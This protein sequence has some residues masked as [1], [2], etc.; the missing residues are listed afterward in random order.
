MIWIT[1]NILRLFL[2]LDW[3][4]DRHRDSV[5]ILWEGLAWVIIFNR[6]FDGSTFLYVDSLRVLLQGRICP[7]EQRWFSSHTKVDFLYWLEVIKTC[8]LICALALHCFDSF[9]GI[10]NL[11]LKLAVAMLLANRVEWDRGLELI[12][13]QLPVTV[14]RLKYASR[15]QRITNFECVL[16]I[17]VL[18]DMRCV[19]VMTVKASQRRLLLLMTPWLR[20]AIALLSEIEN[21]GHKSELGL[22][23]RASATLW[24]WHILRL[25]LVPGF[26]LFISF[27]LSYFP[28][29]VIDDST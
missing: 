18:L 11:Y 6:A 14:I 7:L 10:L 28:P 29:Q 12:V 20:F 4:S 22:N 24:E 17:N 5:L 26:L 1:P 19:T 23:L 15:Q 13:V 8:C 25:S 9:V 16:T 2:G 27:C 21:V 3:T